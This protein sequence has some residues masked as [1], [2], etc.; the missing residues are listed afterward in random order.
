M[1]LVRSWMFVPGNHTRK[2]EKSHLLPADVIIYDLED[3]VPL[4]EKGTAREMVKQ[5]LNVERNHQVF[6]R[7]NDISS[8]YYEEDLEAVLSAGCDGI[9]L[10][11]TCT[12]E[13]IQKTV[14]RIE[15]LE[16]RTG[17]K[18]NQ[19]ELIALIE[20]AQGVQN[21]YLISQANKRLRRLAFG[22]VD[23]IV[24][25]GGELSIEGTELLYARSQLL[26][27]SRAAGIEAPID[28]V[29]MDI[30]DSKNL[31]KETEQVK[32]MGFAGKLVIHPDQISVVNEIF[33]PSQ[34]EIEKSQEIV[35]AFTKAEAQ[36][37]AAIQVGGKLVD[38][39]V[40]KKAK[41]ILRIAEQLQLL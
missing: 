15:H 10:P 29:F 25:I 11:K 9:M 20:S 13:D 22:S 6:V 1:S 38:Y 41:Q 30:K 28:A 24:D 2:M 8:E 18:G 4:T 40:V 36:G 3:A 17:I 7:I 35:M 21:A 37:V 16:H 34:A 12:P 33:T 26:I 23:F 32:R 39:P 14:Q 31:R 5:V 27:A 19:V